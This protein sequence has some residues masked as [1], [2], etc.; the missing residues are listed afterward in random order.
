MQ[1]A[2]RAAR[3]VCGGLTLC[4]GASQL[5]VPSCQPGDSFSIVWTN[6]LVNISEAAP[7]F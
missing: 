6:G 5:A 7:D 2:Q 4:P 3:A 1:G